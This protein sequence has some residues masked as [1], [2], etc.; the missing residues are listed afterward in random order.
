MSAPVIKAM[1]EWL[2]ACPLVSELREGGVLLRVA[3]LGTEPVVLP[4]WQRAPQAR[5]FRRWHWRGAPV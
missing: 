1:Q 5:C 4:L 3:Y 2:K